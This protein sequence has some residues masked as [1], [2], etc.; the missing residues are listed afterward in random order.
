M[1]QDEH[2]GEVWAL[3]RAAQ[4]ARDRIAPW[5]D[6]RVGGEG[7]DFHHSYGLTPSLQLQSPRLA[8]FKIQIAGAIRIF[9]DEDFA[10]SSQGSQRAGKSTVS[11]EYQGGSPQQNKFIGLSP[12]DPSSEALDGARRS[13]GNK[14]ST[15]P[16]SPRGP[17]HIA[18]ASLARSVASTRA[19]VTIF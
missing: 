18:G 15:V 7:N 10:R 9:T 5:W 14:D 13:Q 17:W 8:I 16:R 1:R 6:D 2:A 19:L 3:N 4:E 11:R 12:A